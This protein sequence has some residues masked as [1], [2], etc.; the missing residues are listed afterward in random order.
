MCAFC[1]IAND[2]RIIGIANCTV[3]NNDCTGSQS[4]LI[5][6][7]VSNSGILT[8]SDGTDPHVVNDG[9]A[10]Y[11]YLISAFCSCLH[12]NRNGVSSASRRLNAS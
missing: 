10:T 3:T 8:N 9:I 6:G 4:A 1:V 5:A 11:S 12:T 7:T 2:Y